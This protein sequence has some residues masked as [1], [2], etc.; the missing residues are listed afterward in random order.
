M[1]DI[2]VDRTGDRPLVFKGTEMAA[3]SSRLED[4]DAS[5]GLRA[6]GPSD[7]SSGNRF[8]HIITIYKL[9]RKIGGFVVAVTYETDWE[10]ETD[11]HAAQV[12]ANEAEVADFLRAY[13]PL[14]WFIGPP[15]GGPGSPQEQRRERLTR[16]LLLRYKDAV[17]EVL[18]SL[19]PERVE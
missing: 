17:S 11:H 3:A 15:K 4:G 16:D 6:R 9:A 19:E 12:C 7:T 8:W 5:V 1:A 14:A 18:E 2:T 10:T 13:D